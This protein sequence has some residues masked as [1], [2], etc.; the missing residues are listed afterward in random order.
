MV[1]A[2]DATRCGLGNNGGTRTIVR[3]A[4]TLV[5][6]G[7]TVYIVAVVDRYTWGDASKYCVERVPKDTDV[8]V[9]VSASDV[10]HTLQAGKPCAWW[11]RGWE[12]WNYTSAEIIKMT[13]K[14]PTI[15]ISGWLFDKLDGEKRTLLL[16]VCY[17]GVDDYS[18]PN[19]HRT[20]YG[21]LIN[22]QHVTKRS[23]FVDYCVR[24]IDANWALISSDDNWQCQCAELYRNPTESQKR[25]LYSKCAVWFAPTILEGFHNVAAEAALA[26]CH[27]VCGDCNSNG[28]GDWAYDETVDLYRDDDEAIRLLKNPNVEKAVCA[29]ADVKAIAS[30]HRNM[31]MFVDMLQNIK[32]NW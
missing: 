11:I 2:F 21:A 12:T 22:R 1:I 31:A 9:A 29:K 25:E 14:I 23:D 6:L 3:S 26:G 4:D 28:M 15:P 8:V 18:I 30:R 13:T 20:H 27:I 10:S 16:D 5:Q 32:T 17:A 19:P 7:H 24:S